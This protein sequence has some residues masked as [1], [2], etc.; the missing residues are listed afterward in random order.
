MAKALQ[1]GP[2]VVIASPGRLIEL[3]RT[4]ATNFYRCTVLIFDECDRCFDLG[5]ENQIKSIIGN[6]RPDRQVILFSATLKNNIEQFV[7]TS[8]KSS[9][10]VRI[11]IGKQGQ[12]NAD[13]KQE[14]IVLNYF[15]D[16]FHW[17]KQHLDEFISLGKV[18]I[19][20]NQK[21][22]TEYVSKSIE[23]YFQ[24]QRQL[25][26]KVGFIHGDVDQNERMQIIKKFSR[27]SEEN[28]KNMEV[29]ILV[30]TDVA[31]RGLDIYDIQTVIN[32]DIPKNI[33]TYVHRIGRTGRLSVNGQRPG[34]AYT[35]LVQHYDDGER[36]TQHSSFAVSLVQNLQLSGIT[37]PQE[38]TAF[39]MTDAKS[40]KL[41]KES[42]GGGRDNVNHMNKQGLGIGNRTSFTSE[43]LANNTKLPSNSN[44]NGGTSST[45]SFGKL[46]GTSS[47]QYDGKSKYMY[48]EPSQENLERLPL[49]STAPTLPGFVRSSQNLSSVQGI[50]DHNLS[51]NVNHS[52]STQPRKKSRWDT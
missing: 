43:M 15:R 13:I 34:T 30:A 5:F 9:K 28:S 1:E 24:H 26:V 3:T 11:V 22:T 14:I 12:A 44:I 29:S 6:I 48:D 37:I 33:D 42:H 39:A 7:K 19:F 35:L 31:S 2:N 49:V 45:M 40:F 27:K 50:I 20:V 46:L 10:V 17:L 25:L 21:E 16:K 4:K 47:N 18:L 36:N 32:Y 41:R 23:D 8:I 38:L 51:R 52:T